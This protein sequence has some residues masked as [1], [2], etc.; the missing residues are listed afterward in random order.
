MTITDKI[1]DD[2]K[3]AQKA[4][5]ELKISALRV[6]R[7]EMTNAAIARMKKEL[8]DEEAQS[9]LQMQVKR[10]REA[11]ADFE[12]GGRRDLVEKNLREIKILEQYLPEAATEEEIKKAVAE[13]VA[14][15]GYGAKDFG[16]AM[17]EAM[18]RLKGKADGTAVS[19]ILK[20]MLPK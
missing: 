8:T 5:D 10:L 9:V 11:A 13:L 14:A 17:G 18:A 6:I 4:K 2:L 20:E 7:A 15:G 3:V 16:K 12:K 1:S 19:K